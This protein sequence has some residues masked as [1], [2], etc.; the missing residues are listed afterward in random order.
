MRPD[1]W[2]GVCGGVENVDKELLHVVLA[3]TAVMAVGA[4]GGRGQKYEAKRVEAYEQAIRVV[5]ARH[6]R[7]CIGCGRVYANVWNC[8]CGGVEC[9]SHGLVC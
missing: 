8:T 5:L 2:N 4:E 3:C 1:V 7:C 9:E 6:R